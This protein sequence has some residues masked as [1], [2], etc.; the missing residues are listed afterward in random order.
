MRKI[1]KSSIVL[2][3]VLFVL[4]NVT[5]ATESTSEFNLNDLGSKLKES[6]DTE[7]IESTFNDL[8]DN[9]D[10]NDLESTFNNLK[11]EFDDA[12]ENGS[13][14][15]NL[16]DTMPIISDDEYTGSA[17]S[18][19]FITGD[20]YMLEEGDI[21]IEK[22]VNGNIYVIG[23]NIT[24]YSENVY[25]NIF[26]LAEENLTIASEV[27]GSVYCLAP[28]FE[29]AGSTS[30]V[31]SIS[32]NAH[33]SNNSKIS[34]DLRMVAETANIEGKILGSVYSDVTTLNIDDETAAINGT[35]NYT[36]ELNTNNTNIGELVKSESSLEGTN[37]ELESMG[38]GIETFFTALV[39]AI[40]IIYTILKVTTMVLILAIIIAVLNKKDV[41][42]TDIKE[43]FWRDLLYGLLFTI[44]IPVGAIL[45]MFTIIG[46]PVSLIVILA[47]A[48][49]FNFV[50][51]PLAVIEISKLIYK[52]ECN[53]K[54]KIWL[55][56]VALYVVTVLLNNVPWVG[57]IVN[58]VI[59]VYG[60]GFVL[61]KIFGKKEPTQDIT[62]E[63][64]SDK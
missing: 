38:E 31:Y 43:K 59:S 7:K 37:K 21:V 32:T 12:T 19:E 9:V 55:L 47:Y 61:R 17:S 13:T 39:S 33:F 27:S 51:T 64:L 25:G 18:G 50:N 63:I 34:R 57:A 42:T 29:F 41:Y 45:L 5:L 15:A 28:N 46:I 54:M 49:F 23:K 36:G 14:D 16:Y 60:F 30:D 6:V 2:L 48:I 53:S 10:L 26:A 62:V 52:N 58:F 8:K 4:T 35:L 3:I 56:A 20:I 24:I 22:N 44:V 11:N 1:L 40:G